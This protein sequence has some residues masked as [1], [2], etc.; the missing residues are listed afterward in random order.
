MLYSWQ[1]SLQYGKTTFEQSTLYCEYN[2]VLLC[3]LVKISKYLQGFGK[4]VTND[5]LGKR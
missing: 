4:V 3:D 2:V 1:A 5:S